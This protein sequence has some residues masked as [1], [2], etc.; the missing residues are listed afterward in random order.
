MKKTHRA[1]SLLLIVLLFTVSCAKKEE[2]IV[3]ELKVEEPKV[4][5]QEEAKEVVEKI[6]KEEKVAI[7]SL[8]S[9]V[10]TTKELAELPVVGIMLDNHPNARWQAGLREAEVVYEIRVEGDFTRYLALYQVTDPKV[11]GPIRSARTPFVN[12]ILEY[13]AIYVHYGGSGQGNA[14][15]NNFDV[16]HI[17]GMAVGEPV[18]YR[19]YYV[20]KDA[21]HNAYSSMEEI[22]AYAKRQNFGEKTEFKGYS[23]YD[24]PTAPGG[25]KANEFTLY[26]RPGNKTAYTYLPEERV[27]HR[28]KD[29]SLHIDE[30]DEEP[31]EVVNVIVQFSD[32]FIVDNVGHLDLEDVGEGRGLLFTQGEVVEITWKKQDRQAPTEFFNKEGKALQLNIGQTFIQVVDEDINIEIE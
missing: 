8:L 1:M 23:F 31:L 26:L 20:G 12:R 6:E 7:R 10:E 21:P 3:E 15:I 27:Y 13:N 29:G 19:N 32:G 24:K 4:E 16:E 18:Y 28:Y 14:D 25:E 17:D 30:N 9:G 5:I 2:P 22:R 11:I